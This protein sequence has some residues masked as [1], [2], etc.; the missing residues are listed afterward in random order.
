VVLSADMLLRRQHQ[1]VSNGLPV[2]YT[3]FRSFTVQSNVPDV[4]S[5]SLR[6]LLYK[7]VVVELQ[8]M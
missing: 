2:A 6:L 5:V 1:L 7:F 8:K 4:V 3:L